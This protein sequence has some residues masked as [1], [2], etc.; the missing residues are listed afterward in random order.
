[1]GEVPLN[2]DGQPPRR[3]HRARVADRLVAELLGL[4]KGVVCDGVVT[5]GEAAGLRRWL[6][7]HPEAALGYP[8]NVLLDRFARIFADGF[9]DEEERG[10]LLELMQDLTGET[11]ET[12]QPM[13]LSAT[14]FFDNPLPTVVFESQE[15][16]FTGRMLY[17]SRGQCETAVKDRGGQVG[18]R[19]TKRT[20]FVVVGPI[21]S[22][23]WLQSTHGQ[24]LLDAARYR[25]SGV[26]VKII[27][28][29]HWIQALEWGA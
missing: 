16:V 25:E 19:V 5:E 15:Y 1:M 7:G 28:E 9:A 12:D 20:D 3:F 24:K 23:A 27:P 26:P 2:E 29:E 6:A 22:E 14:T 4:C 17:G 13:N 11:P 8:G 21:G 18:K 10:E